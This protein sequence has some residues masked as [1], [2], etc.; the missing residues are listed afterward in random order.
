MLSLVVPVWGCSPW[1]P[2]SP[3]PTLVTE[4]SGVSAVA[5]AGGLAPWGE[6]A[7][8]M[9]TGPVVTGVRRLGRLVAE[10]TLVALVALAAVGEGVEG[11]A[12]PMHTPVGT[13]HCQAHA[14]TATTCMAHQHRA[15]RGSAP[16]WHQHS[17][18][19]GTATVR[20]CYGTSLVTT[21]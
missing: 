12:Q 16:A 14:S 11:Q 4:G 18:A 6:A 19:Q 13:Q 9:D 21:T 5:L 3:A 10:G 2:T 7:V 20:H 15:W 1:A 17:I 8:A